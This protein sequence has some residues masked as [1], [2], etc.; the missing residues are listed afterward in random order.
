ML[1]HLPTLSKD[2]ALATLSHLYHADETPAWETVDTGEPPFARMY[3][4]D[5]YVIY[6]KG[7]ILELDPAVKEEEVQLLQAVE[8]AKSARSGG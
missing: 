6:N 7:G 4:N 1:E 3:R 5:R 2:A 8:M